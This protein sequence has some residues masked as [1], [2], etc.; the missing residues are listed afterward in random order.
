MSRIASVLDSI[1][2]TARRV[3]AGRR[4]N[5]F[6]ERSRAGQG[7]YVTEQEVERRHPFVASDLLRT[8]PGVMVSVGKDNEHV[9]SMRRCVPAVY[10]DGMESAL[11]LDEIPT[12]WIHGIEVYQVSE[13]PSQYRGRGLCGLILVWTK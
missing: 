5:E 1:R 2:V 7:R 3:A 8:T 13:I 11:P 12:S 10:L 9:V 6:D 4:Y